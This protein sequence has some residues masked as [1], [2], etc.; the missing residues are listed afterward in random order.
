MILV[1]GL[2]LNSM[3]CS[4][5]ERRRKLLEKDYPDIIR[6]WSSKSVDNLI[7][8]A[9]QGNA[10]Q[11]DHIVPVFGGGGECDLINLRTLCTCC[12]QKVTSEQNNQRRRERQEAKRKQKSLGT[13]LIGKKKKQRKILD[14]DSEEDD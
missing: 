1:Y 9:S 2:K 14:E 10:W 13:L 3:C 6:N 5:K 12:H 4:W 11:A 8:R 7:A